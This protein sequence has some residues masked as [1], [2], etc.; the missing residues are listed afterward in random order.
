MTDVLTPIITGP[1][2]IIFIIV[3]RSFGFFFYSSRK[4]LNASCLASHVLTKPN[5]IT[6]QFGECFAVVDPI[7]AFTLGCMKG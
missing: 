7:S 4:T 5:R 2:S 3:K 1:P 6:Q